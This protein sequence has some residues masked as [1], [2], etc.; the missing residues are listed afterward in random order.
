MLGKNLAPRA[1]EGA[2]QTETWMAA[3]HRGIAPPYLASWD[4]K[5]IP[6]AGRGKEKVGISGARIMARVCKGA[7]L[8]AD[9]LHQQISAGES[10]GAGLI[11]TVGD[12][13]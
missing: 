3:R 2:K 10:P 9:P 7:N 11:P 1:A 5:C 8:G 12:K 13:H 6:G 4:G